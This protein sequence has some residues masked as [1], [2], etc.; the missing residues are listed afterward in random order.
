MPRAKKMS[1]KEKKL[2][3]QIDDLKNGELASVRNDMRFQEAEQAANEASSVCNSLRDALHEKGCEID[4]LKE[5]NRKT[6][7]LADDYKKA[8]NDERLETIRLKN[9]IKELKA[10]G[11][12]G[13]LKRKH[14][15][16]EEKNE[17]LYEE[18]DGLKV[19]NETM[20]DNLAKA[21]KERKD[22][23]A[24]RN[25]A[26]HQL[27]AREGM[28]YDL[29]EKFDKTDR[30]NAKLKVQNTKL[31]QQRDY[32]K[33]ALGK[34]TD[35]ASLQE[36]VKEALAC[37]V[38]TQ[39]VHN[40]AMKECEEA[41]QKIVDGTWVTWAAVENCVMTL[42]NKGVYRDVDDTMFAYPTTDAAF[43][44]NQLILDTKLYAKLLSIVN[45]HGEYIHNNPHG[46]KDLVAYGKRLDRT[47]NQFKLVW[48]KGPAGK[49]LRV[50]NGEVITAD[51][52]E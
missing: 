31:E 27:Y 44:A 33:E 32:Y 49:R 19:D 50:E 51:D 11:G 9:K 29:V 20:R 35:E 28:Y 52:D 26:E 40:K 34:K 18:I 3:K 10:T 39:R 37:V 38:T 15:E 5:E 14:D 2:Q 6:Q 7:G 46:A 42:A 8:F 41:L 23:D 30:E 16:L 36:Q 17:G 4:G 21:E 43:V 13:E 47:V 1:E 48:D 45:P 12:G 24:G 22:A 25:T